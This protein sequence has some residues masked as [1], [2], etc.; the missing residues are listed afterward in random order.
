MDL[1]KK[2]ETSLL[3]TSLQVIFTSFSLSFL[4]GV[5]G[6]FNFQLGQSPLYKNLED[7]VCFLMNYTWGK[8]GKSKPWNVNELSVNDQ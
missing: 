1:R 5:G 2:E 4:G 3:E 8:K 7:H 6:L